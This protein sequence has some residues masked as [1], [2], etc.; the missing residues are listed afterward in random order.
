MK[1]YHLWNDARD[2]NVINAYIYLPG[3]L[4]STKTSIH[5]QCHKYLAILEK[6]RYFLAGDQVKISW[7][8]IS[9]ISSKLMAKKSACRQCQSIIKHVTLYVL[10]RCQSTSPRMKPLPLQPPVRPQPPQLLQQPPLQLPQP[11][12]LQPLLQQPLQQ[13]PDPPLILTSPIMTPGM[14]MQLSCR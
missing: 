9:N 8:L 14:N 11:Q 3:Y 10:L 13:L 6:F 5:V 7:Q 4:I 1:S 2:I 12:L